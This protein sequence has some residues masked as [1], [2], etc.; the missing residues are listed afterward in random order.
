MDKQ[1]GESEEEEVMGAGIGESEMGENGLLRFAICAEKSTT[2]AT[3]LE[4][5]R[6][7]SRIDQAQPYMY[8]ILK[9]W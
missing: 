5:S 3:S 8:P 2:I 7:V 9:I 6:K 1:S 4:Q